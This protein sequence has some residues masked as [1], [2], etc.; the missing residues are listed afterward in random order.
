MHLCMLTWMNVNMQTCMHGHIHVYL[1][2]TYT[3]T[4]IGTYLHTYMHTIVAYVQAN[5][6][7]YIEL[8]RLKVAKGVS[9][10]LDWGECLPRILLM[11]ELCMSGDALRIF[12]LSS[13]AQT[14][15]AFI[16]RLMWPRPF[17]S[18]SEYVWLRWLATAPWPPTPPPSD[19]KL[20]AD[21]RDNVRIV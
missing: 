8:S 17:S 13:F 4:Y 9:I 7:V 18:A 2:W 16:G 14:M 5:V 20:D 12:L 21:P 1:N 6:Q 3:Y 10:V 15:K 11:L 19:S